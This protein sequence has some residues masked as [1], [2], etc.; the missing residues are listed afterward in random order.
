MRKLSEM[1][2]SAEEQHRPGIVLDTT[3]ETEVVILDATLEKCGKAKGYERHV[4]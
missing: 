1:S 2:L 4:W 3:E